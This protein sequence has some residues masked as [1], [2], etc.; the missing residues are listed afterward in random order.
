MKKF[1]ILLFGFLL[2]LFLSGT[3]TAISI[4]NGS[5]ETGLTGWSSWSSAGGANPV[6]NAFG[7]NPTDGNNFVDISGTSYITQNTSWNEGDTLSFDW[8]FKAGDYLPFNDYVRFIISGDLSFEKTL[9]N[10]SS[11]GNYG[12]IGWGTFTYN[13]SS[14]GNGSIR[15]AVN[16]AGDNSYNSHF[17]V[18]NVLGTSNFPH[19]PE[20][21]TMLLFGS[22]LIGLA[23]FSRRFNKS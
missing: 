21:T 10:V 17:L 20:P 13:F 4:D 14:A 6:T 2:I 16:N 9:S 15:F 11:V 5:F 23:G 1:T 19:A 8:A 3:A 7:F 18:D 22:G 12:S